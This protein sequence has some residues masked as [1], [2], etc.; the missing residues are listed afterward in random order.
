VFT[1]P[2]PE[3]WI[4][5]INKDTTRYGSYFYNNKNDVARFVV[6][7]KKSVRYYET[8]TTDIDLISDFT[9]VQT[10]MMG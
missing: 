6:I 1:I 4:V 2:N 10:C 7:P 3:D 8:L 5:V 9:R